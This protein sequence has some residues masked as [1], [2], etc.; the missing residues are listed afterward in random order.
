[1]PDQP[2]IG[3]PARE[4]AQQ[5]TAKQRLKFFSPPEKPALLGKSIHADADVTDL[6]TQS[7]AA[8]ALPS[9]QEEAAA[10][11]TAL[12]SPAQA[13]NPELTSPVYLD[14][15]MAD[16]SDP[17]IGFEQPCYTSEE[18]AVKASIRFSSS[19]TD[20]QPSL[21][22]LEETNGDL[23]AAA[24]TPSADSGAVGSANAAAAP[25]EARGQASDEPMR[26]QPSQTQSVRAAHLS[27]PVEPEHLDQHPSKPPAQ[28]AEVLAIS[29]GAL[30][31]PAP[32]SSGVSDS[33]G[34]AGSLPS[35]ATAESTS[36]QPEDKSQTI[37]ES[38]A[39]S[40]AE[41]LS[42]RQSEDAHGREAGAEKHA[43]APSSAVPPGEAVSAVAEPD[44]RDSASQHGSD[45]PRIYE[46][47]GAPEEAMGGQTGEHS[48]GSAVPAEHVATRHLLSQPHE[49]FPKSDLRQA[50]AQAEEHSLAV[51]LL[52]TIVLNEGAAGSGSVSGADNSGPASMPVVAEPQPPTALPETEQD[53]PS[54]T[55]AEE[56]HFKSTISP[57]AQQALEAAADV[58]VTAP[59]LPATR[60]TAARLPVPPPVALFQRQPIGSP[61][62]V[63]I[64][65]PQVP[66]A[67]SMPTKSTKETA[68]SPDAEQH[69]RDK[70]DS[71]GAIAAEDEAAELESDATDADLLALAEEV[72]RLEE[73]L[74]TAQG[75]A[76]RTAA[77]ADAARAEAESAR[78]EAAEWR[79]R[80]A[81]ARAEVRRFLLC[82][83]MQECLP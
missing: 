76:E 43:E 26:K 68:T 29:P 21:N 42:Q 23:S 9:E 35:P 82:S 41:E 12:N 1:M 36:A 57:A 20:M 30:R 75:A 51:Q 18:E 4:G 64:S 37:L 15:Q 3:Q 24:H 56:D 77:R 34:T 14:A 8:S 10:A 69:I 49:K 81:D 65:A 38:P 22:S 6:N 31:D 7:S 48:A 5:R 16:Q 63:P 50:A 40:A 44:Q 73:E 46:H 28:A 11:N 33:S 27:S 25:V 52:P 60:P 71:E 55:E 70:A 79:E 58:P 54:R 32:V 19:G 39:I 17:V 47:G 59:P 62:Q 66:A 53:G 61:S 83:V 13:S 74:A 45:S 2:L 78:A 72:G 67:V 80:E